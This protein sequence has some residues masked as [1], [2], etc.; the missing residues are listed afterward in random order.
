MHEGGHVTQE[1]FLM[2]AI[3]HLFTPEMRYFYFIK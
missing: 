1:D 2:F 3:F